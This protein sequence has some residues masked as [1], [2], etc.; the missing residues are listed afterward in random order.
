MQ[1]QETINSSNSI[2]SK[3]LEI[4]SAKQTKFRDGTSFTDHF[5]SKTNIEIV[6]KERI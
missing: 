1:I 4:I 6:F 3:E 5:G 2:E